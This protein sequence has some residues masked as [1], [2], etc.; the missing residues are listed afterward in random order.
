MT[1]ATMTNAVL[2]ERQQQQ[3]T[4]AMLL[5]AK[6]DNKL[7]AM[8]GTMREVQINDAEQDLRL[9]CN[10]THLKQLEAEMKDIQRQTWKV[11]IAV[12]VLAG[13]TMEGVKAVAGLLT[14]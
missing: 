5:L 6:I 3:H 1:G 13:A 9:S 7:Q 12:A 10:T 4:Q 14:P 8:N 11:A 2:S